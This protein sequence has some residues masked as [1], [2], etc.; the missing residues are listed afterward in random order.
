MI[1]TDWKSKATEYALDKKQLKKRIKELTQS[2][3]QWKEKAMCHKARAD[4]F[5]AD[6][7]KLKS[8]LIEMIDY[9]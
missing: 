7:K 9:Q 5:E 3:D 4:K 1:K 6:L 2:R 8:K